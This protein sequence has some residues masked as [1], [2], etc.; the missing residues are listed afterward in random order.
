MLQKPVPKSWNDVEIIL[1]QCPNDAVM[2]GINTTHSNTGN[3]M[4][5]LNSAYFRQMFRGLVSITCN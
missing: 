1:N 2:C 3:L 5:T 4:D